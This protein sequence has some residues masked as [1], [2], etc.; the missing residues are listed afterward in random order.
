MSITV[1]FTSLSKRDNSTK[2]LTMSVTHSC[3]FKNGCSMLN[4]TLLLEISSNT[5]PDYTEFKIDD[6]YYKVTDIRSVRNNLFEIDGKVDV[7]ASFKTQIGASTEYVVRSASTSD[8]LV[9]DKLYPTK[10]DPIFES[11]L[12]EGDL[13]AGP[14]GKIYRTGT[15]VIGIKNKYGK[16]GLSFYALT[17]TQM[18]NLMSYM[19]SDVWLD[20][21]DITQNLQKMLNNPMDYISCCYWYPLNIQPPS[22]TFNTNIWF[23]YWNSHVEGYEI[24]ESARIQVLYDTVTLVGHPQISRGK[25]LNGS[26][27]TRLRAVIFGFGSIPLDSSLVLESTDNSL[28][29]GAY[30]RLDL[31][32]GTGEL[33]LSSQH[34][35]IQSLTAMVGVPVQISQVTQDLI[36]PMISVLKA[37]ESFARENVIGTISGITDALRECFPQ[38]Q[39]MGAIGSPAAYQEAARIEA[40]YFLLT[41]EDQAQLGR[42][43][44]SPRQINTLSGYIKCE[45]VD[46]DIACTDSERKEII[47]YME[48]GFFYE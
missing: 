42:P 25:Y 33:K 12:F 9:I 45:N 16:Y 5:F 40:N 38:V 32:T 41:D 46:I 19:F 21:T 13:S 44:C 4:P 8:P 34:G 24:Q 23:G 10:S 3:N 14:N 1:S 28:T 17:P 30:I 36:K 29:I 39:T 27:F 7:L 35:D 20:A 37:S 18:E 6:R 2:Q 26:P 43:L 22:Q 11:K 15:Y 31:F 47:A 48:N